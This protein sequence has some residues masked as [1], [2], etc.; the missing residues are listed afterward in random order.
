MIS[1][2]RLGRLLSTGTET[3]I[4][5]YRK[6]ELFLNEQ[7]LYGSPSSKAASPGM[8]GSCLVSQVLQKMVTKSEAHQRRRVRVLCYETN[9]LHAT[10]LNSTHTPSMP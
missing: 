5:M 4:P 10:T 8:K 1:Q 7:A 9:G 6:G 2:E 3:Q